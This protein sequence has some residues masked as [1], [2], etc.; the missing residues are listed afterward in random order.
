MFSLFGFS[1]RERA[2]WATI[3]YS[4]DCSGTC[5]CFDDRPDCFNQCY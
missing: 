4:C 1:V 3:S 2:S 5:M